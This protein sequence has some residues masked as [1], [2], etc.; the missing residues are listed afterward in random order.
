MTELRDVMRWSGACRFFR[1]DPVQDEVLHRIFDVVRFGPSGGNRQPVRYVVVRDPVTKRRLRELYLQAWEPY[2]A[3]LGVGTITTTNSSK[4]VVAADH[5]ARHLDEIPAH[6]VVCARLADLHVTDAGLDRLSIVGGASVY[7]SVQNLL[8]AC[9]DL[10]LGS[11]L[12]T[13]LVEFEPELKEL[14]A[15]PPEF[16]IA[17]TVAI[18]YPDQKLP[19][20][21]KRLPV[22]ELVSI[23]RFGDAL[24]V[25]G[26]K[27]VA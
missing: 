4:V 23:E 18:G 21:L 3:G 25:P 5:F 27:T 17:C 13:L 15:I 7:P 24:P 1:P 26:A 14:L 2:I 11:A 8:L 16:A 20:R 9:R 6:V 22:E 19:T 12:T 10:E